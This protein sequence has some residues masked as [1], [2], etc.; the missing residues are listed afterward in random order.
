MH[1]EKLESDGIMRL[2][3]RTLLA[4]LDDTLPPKDVAR[5][6]RQL[7]SSKFAQDLS[8]RIRRVVRQRRLTV[9]GMGTNTPI[10]SNIIGAY[11]DNSL[12]GDQTSAVESLA[13][14]SDVHLAEIA[15]CHQILSLLEQPIE[16]SSDTHA[17]MYRLVKGPE[18]R[19]QS[20]RWLEQ[21]RDRATINQAE[22]HLDL[23]GL[24][25]V[26]LETLVTSSF[27]RHRPKFITGILFFGLMMFGLSQWLDIQSGPRLATLSNS[28]K[29]VSQDHNHDVELNDHAS[30]E[31]SPPQPANKS[32]EVVVLTDSAD[33]KQAIESVPVVEKSDVPV[34]PIDQVNKLAFLFPDFTTLL[35]KSKDS[36]FL[37]SDAVPDQPGNQAAGSR[38][39]EKLNPGDSRTQGTVRFASAEPTR[40][41]TPTGD[42]EIQSG[43]LLDWY[44]S[45]TPILWQGQ[46]RFASKTGCALTVR[47]DKKNEM[48]LLVHPDSTIVISRMNL[49]MD[50]SD[51]TTPLAFSPA[52]LILEK[53]NADFTFQEKIIHC[54]KEKAVSLTYNEADASL[55]YSEVVPAPIV[56]PTP[57]VVSTKMVT[58]AMNRY[59]NNNR[60]LPVGIMDAVSDKIKAVRD[61]ALNIAVWIDRDDIIVNALTDLGNIELRASAVDAIRKSALLRT[62]AAPR[63]TMKLAQELELDR[64]TSRLLNQLLVNPDAKGDLSWKKVLVENLE[65]P[66]L[67]IRQLAL[68]HLMKIAARDDMGYKPENPSKK[69]FEAWQSWLGMD[70]VID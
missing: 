31:T 66:S 14:N 33:K 23:D 39:W 44:S 64:D 36:I 22:L 2:T 38:Q 21:T 26:S 62:G 18:A 32:E 49:K 5:I 43:S 13:L 10:D 55:K 42:I 4:W 16:T 25:H 58:E 51:L 1:L 45:G 7:H 63:I 56:E 11:L 50:Q 48:K 57:A 29:P 28:L 60:P 3:L 35:S 53:G 40:F 24:D 30:A 65:N 70:G 34:A 46:M 41:T 37:V 59:L 27:N 17:K 20:E 12:P 69:G 54:S 6:G 67:L 47:I 9:P 8:R 15:A 68:E 19:I 52:L 61:L